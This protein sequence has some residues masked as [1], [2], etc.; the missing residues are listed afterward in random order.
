[1]ADFK[2]KSLSNVMGNFA[3]GDVIYNDKGYNMTIDSA[4][5]SSHYYPSSSVDTPLNSV[6]HGG[7]YKYSGEILFNE[8]II[9]ITR[10]ID[11]K[12]N[13]KIVFEF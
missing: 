5:L 4:S 2:I 6:V 1:M 13:F 7:L 9:P 10:R 11:Q 12:E 8:N 3:N